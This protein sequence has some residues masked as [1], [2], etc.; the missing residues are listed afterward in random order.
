MENAGLLAALRRHVAL[1]LALTLVGLVL[2]AVVTAVLPRTYE[3][4]ATLF[5]RVQAASTS[6]YERSQFALQRVQ[7]Y[8]ALLDSPTL[9]RS[10]IST[11]Q[12]KETTQQLA[13]EVTAENPTNTVLLNV[14]ASASTP[15]GAAAIANAAADALAKNVNTLEN[16]ETASKNAVTLVP[17]I[18]AQAP[19]SPSS[20]NR[21]VVLGLGLV[22]GFVLGAL[23]ALLLER[24]RPRVRTIADVR[25]V[26]GLPV[27]AQLP[28]G[29][30]LAEA[31]AATAAVN[32]R[33][34]ARG[35][36]PPVV[37]LAPAEARAARAGAHL[38]TS[39]GLAQSGRRT[40][41][42]IAPSDP[43][44]PLG[45]TIAP[46][47]PGL[48]E[49]LAGRSGVNEVTV[50]VKDRGFEV[51]PTG[52]LGV[53]PSAFELEHSAQQML[54]PLVTARDVVVLQA[55]LASR[56]L[57]LGT[58]GRLARAALLVVSRRSTTEH[59]LRRLLAE[60]RVLDIVPI[61]VLMTDVGAPSLDLIETWTDTD[62]L[63]IEFEP[64]AQQPI[65][66]EHAIGI[67]T[68]AHDR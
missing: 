2:A 28:R 7:S 42:L 45:V 11:A 64:A 50:P 40:V 59:D 52:A 35:H 14:T 16:N 67:G 34:I 58:A 5:L 37:L 12:L 56:P 44:A 57:D 41:A 17:Q 23:L 36:V 61:G 48:S 29:G 9:L 20:P 25:R 49:L 31:A 55:D 62:F 60:V 22:A 66:G 13:Q 63:R 18:S 47:A 32:L 38:L 39:W 46:S 27:I 3:A 21:P 53:A 54:A 15:D 10:V 65:T 24:V 68:T 51:V 33:T 1:V 19:A 8:P 6:L 30:K 26:S 43:I 4:K